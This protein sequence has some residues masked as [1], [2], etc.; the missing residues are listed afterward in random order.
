[1]KLFYVVDIYRDAFDLMDQIQRTHKEVHHNLEE[2]NAKY[3]ETVD[4][5][6]RF[7]EFNVGDL[8]MVHLRKA[9]FPLVHT[10]NSRIGS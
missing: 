2:A 4:R 1:M 8:V 7:K 5:H 6:R 9:C 10:T 3:K